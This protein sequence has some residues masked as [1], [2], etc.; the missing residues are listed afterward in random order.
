LIVSLFWRGFFHLSLLYRTRTPGVVPTTSEVVGRWHEVHRQHEGQSTTTSPIDD[1]KTANKERDN[2]DT[3][4]IDNT[5]V[6][7]EDNVIIDT[8]LIDS[9][10]VISDSKVI[11]NTKLFNNT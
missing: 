4:F 7:D 1:L 8:K 10:I 11:D 6:I 5:K 2:D 3:K 9:T